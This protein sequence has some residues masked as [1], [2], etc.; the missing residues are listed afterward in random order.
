MNILNVGLIKNIIIWIVGIVSY[1]IIGKLLNGFTYEGAYVLRIVLFLL[2]AVIVSLLYYVN[3]QLR[4]VNYGEESNLFWR[5]TERYVPFFIL[6]PV[7]V[8]LFSFLVI[9]FTYLPDVAPYNYFINYCL[10]LFPFYLLV[11]LNDLSIYV[12]H[13]DELWEVKNT[14]R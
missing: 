13:L 4:S 6:F 12:E 9:G 11:F 10:G 2:L 3:I 7:M 14:N 1:F 5:W 8:F